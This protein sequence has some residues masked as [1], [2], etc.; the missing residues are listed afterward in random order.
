MLWTKLFFLF[1]ESRSLRYADQ[2]DPYQQQCESTVNLIMQQFENYSFLLTYQSKF[3]KDEWLTP[4]TAATLKKLPSQ[5]IKNI[6]VIT[7][8]FVSDCLVAL[9]E[10]EAE[11]KNDVIEN[12]GENF[13]Y[14]HPFNDAEDFIDLLSILAAE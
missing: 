14:I 12:G 2:G 3:G 9:E 6:L 11:N 4:A 7:P 10:I 5:G 8:G 13:I 1:M